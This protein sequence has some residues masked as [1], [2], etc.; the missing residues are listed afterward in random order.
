MAQKFLVPINLN[1]NE[2]QNARLQNLASA[3]GSPA[4]G[5][6]YYDTALSTARQ[7]N[8]TSW[9]NLD[10]SKAAAG[11]IP[12]S[13]LATDPLNRANHTGTQLSTTISDLATTVKAYKLSDFA[14]PTA[15]V[16][17]G[18]QVVSNVATPVAGTDAAN[19]QYVDDKQ[20]GLS[21]KDEVQCASTAN[22]SLSGLAAID[23]YTPVAGDRVLVKDQTTTSAN[24]I[25]VAASGSWT[26]STDAD[27]AAKITGAVMFV[28]NGTT[29]GGQRYVLTTSGTITLGTTGLSFGIFGGG[30]SYSAGNGLTLS[31]N[32]FAVNPA[33][34]GGIAV[35]ASGVSL[36]TTI[37]V[38][39]Y[40]ATIGDGTTTSIPVTHGL[41]TQD[42]TV[43][44]QDAST[45]AVVMCDIVATSTTQAT[46]S[47]TTAP[48]SNSLRVVIHG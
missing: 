16:S 9:V 5:Q 27:T 2:L 43:Q 47:F 48:A 46:L 30:T 39:K 37:A 20:A 21:W 4:V 10:A 26:R 38:R 15:T 32:T 33:A 31:S 34:S 1:Q 3:P 12:L 7:W 13:V 8:G 45:R 29:N 42:I 28:Q 17:M 24:G 25:Y 23:G 14:A 41:G 11:T 44:V 35:S 18:S 22:L 19:K 40:V 36:D 6:V